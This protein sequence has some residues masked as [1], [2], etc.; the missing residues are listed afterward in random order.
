MSKVMFAAGGANQ[1]GVGE[2]KPVLYFVE[3]AAVEA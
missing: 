2:V 1:S 3:V